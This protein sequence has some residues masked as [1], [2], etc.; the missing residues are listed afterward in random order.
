LYSKN[1]VISDIVTEL[2]ERGFDYKRDGPHGK[3]F[4]PNRHFV[5]AVPLTPSDWR[6]EKNFRADVRRFLRTHNYDPLAEDAEQE[7]KERKL[8]NPVVVTPAKKQEEEKVT[9]SINEVDFQYVV[10]LHKAGKTYTEICT[11]LNAQGYRL[12]SGGE[13][14]MGNL[15]GW[16]TRRG[17]QPKV[18][19]YG[20][21]T[22]SVSRIREPASPPPPPPPPPP[23]EQERPSK[24]FP[25]LHDVMEIVSSNL[26]DE[27]KETFLKH[28]VAK[29]SEIK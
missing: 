9:K 4:A 13:I 15:S 18:A 14:K 24:K 27:L 3:L 28:V 2:V 1:E 5:V 10:D 11:I 19:A 12:P 7:R 17:Y 6:A 26:S 8:F 23:Q 20:K 21:Y 25:L 29:H 16:L 22:T